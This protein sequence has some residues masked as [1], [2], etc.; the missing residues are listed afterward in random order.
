MVEKEDTTLSVIQLDKYRTSKEKQEE[1]I[2]ELEVWEMI[3][4]LEPAEM[5]IVTNVSDKLRVTK[6]RASRFNTN[7]EELKKE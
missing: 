2:S 3:Q 4:K 1:Y 6:I 7:P 5:M